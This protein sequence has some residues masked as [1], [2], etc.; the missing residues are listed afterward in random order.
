MKVSFE[1]IL[2][3]V[4]RTEPDDHAAVSRARRRGEGLRAGAQ[5][6]RARAD[7][8][9]G[10]AALPG[11]REDSQHP[12]REPVPEGPHHIGGPGSKPHEIVFA[13]HT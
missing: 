1:S 10:Q 12:R 8:V 13:H 9:L 7:A 6:E 4:S 2:F 5:V 3:P 11:G